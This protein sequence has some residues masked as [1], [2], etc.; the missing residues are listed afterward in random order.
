M[1]CITFWKTGLPC[2]FSSKESACNGGDPGSTPGSRRSPREGNGNPLQYSCL[3]NPMD[4]GAW[5]ATVHGVAKNWT[6]LSDWR[7]E[8]KD[9][10]SYSGGRGIISQ[11]VDYHSS[12]DLLWLASELSWH[13][14]VCPFVCAYLLS[15]VQ[16]FVT[17]GTI[18][19]QPP[20]SMG[21]FRQEY[22]SG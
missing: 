15:H 2:R 13:W 10:S 4:G 21:F 11:E 5:W 18:T 17:P 16:L 20:L 1:T 12:F 22:W 8:Y 7:T 19:C 14:W 6:Q 3:K 9:Y